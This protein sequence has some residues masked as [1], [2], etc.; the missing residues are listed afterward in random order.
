LER[1]TDE[2]EIERGR[3]GSRRPNGR[4]VDEVE[5]DLVEWD[6]RSRRPLDE[7]KRDLKEAES[8]VR[9]GGGRDRVKRRIKK[10]AY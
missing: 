9:R 6:R 5:G 7:G 2:E 4:R 10:K 3:G 8:S 1:S